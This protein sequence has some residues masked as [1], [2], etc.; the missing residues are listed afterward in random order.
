MESVKCKKQL[1]MKISSLSIISVIILLLIGCSK[2]EENP[3]WWTW[4]YQGEISAL[5][6]GENWENPLIIGFD[7]TTSGRISHPG[8]T[9]GINRYNIIGF[10]RES[11]NFH[12]IP[13]EVGRYNLVALHPNKT[14]LPT[15]SY[16]TILEDGDVLGDEYRFL[17]T[18]ENYISIDSLTEDNGIYGTFEVNVVRDTTRPRAFPETTDTVRFTIGKFHTILTEN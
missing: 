12:Q 6:N 15:V 11:L 1:F 2:E 4:D 13:C 8:I 10:R 3:E 18:G 16:V 5:R 14:E 9:I 17:A 7:H